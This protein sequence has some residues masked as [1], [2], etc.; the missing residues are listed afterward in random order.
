VGKK[1]VVFANLK[2]KMLV[3]F[4]SHG[5]VMCVSNSDKSV[6]KILDPP[7]NSKP[8]DLVTIDG[9]TNN[10]WDSSAKK[11]IKVMDQTKELMRVNDKGLAVFD[12]KELKINDKTINNVVKN[13]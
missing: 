5:M 10:N 8:G 2:E 13:G 11:I 6:V 4:Q 9:L 12:G 7:T 1:V 3:G